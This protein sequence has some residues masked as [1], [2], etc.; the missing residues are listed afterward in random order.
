MVFSANHYYVYVIFIVF[1][2]ML[3]KQ[4]YLLLHSKL[5]LVLKKVDNVKSQK[6]FV[7]TSYIYIYILFE[8]HVKLIKKKNVFYI[9]CFLF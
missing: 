7:Q 5:I 6:E 9:G 1:K 2:N 3:Y 4:Y 8:F